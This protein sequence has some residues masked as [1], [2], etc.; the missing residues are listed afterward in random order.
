MSVLINK[1][2]NNYNKKIID[3]TSNIN[4]AE[5]LPWINHDH[6]IPLDDEDSIFSKIN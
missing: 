1:F 4:K 3:M 6:V 5:N 2:I